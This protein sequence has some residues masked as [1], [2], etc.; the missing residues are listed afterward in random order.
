[1]SW[2]N[3]N[4]EKTL[5]TF[6]RSRGTSFSSYASSATNPPPFDIAKDVND[7]PFAKTDSISRAR[8]STVSGGA[9]LT[10]GLRV[11]NENTSGKK[12]SIDE[13]VGPN[14][15]QNKGVVKRKSSIK[16]EDNKDAKKKKEARTSSPVTT[17]LSPVQSGTPGA[18]GQSGM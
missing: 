18:F 12:S 16:A 5:K 14:A 6:G 1:M 2:L 7:D 13:K 8:A 15:A 17:A 3:P 9:P 4:E 11:H 10:R